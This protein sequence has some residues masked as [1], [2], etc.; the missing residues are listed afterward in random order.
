MIRI[1]CRT[2]KLLS[3]RMCAFAQVSLLCS[4]FAKLCFKMKALA[5][6]F[7][8]TRCCC[9]VARFRE[10]Q[11]EQLSNS[12]RHLWPCSASPRC[13]QLG[14]Q[15][16]TELEPVT[17][18]TNSSRPLSSCAD[19]Q[20]TGVTCQHSGTTWCAPLT[21]RLSASSKK[22]VSSVRYFFVYSLDD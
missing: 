5:R 9:N 20:P 12:W 22:F 15:K 18:W 3:C 2:Q 14:N 10:R 6:R 16:L 21:P 1:S 19:I 7:R 8:V 17:S 11:R 4:Q 13:G